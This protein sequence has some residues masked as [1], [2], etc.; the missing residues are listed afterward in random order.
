MANRFLGQR[1]NGLAQ[2]SL[3]VMLLKDTREQEAVFGYQ[4]FKKCGR[5]TIVQTVRTQRG[6]LGWWLVKMCELCGGASVVV[7]GR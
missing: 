3:V 2:E 5:T 1:G 4:L 6:L 7:S